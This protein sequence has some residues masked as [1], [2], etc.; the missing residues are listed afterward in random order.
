MNVI[1]LC[2]H[3]L[4]PDWL[5]R[6]GMRRLMDE[7]LRKESAGGGLARRQRF[8]AM[9]R[10]LEASPIALHTES[11]NDQHYELPAA[12]F[13]HI[14]GKRFKYSACFWPTASTSLDEAE[15]EMLALT[16]QRAE[17]ADGMS[18]LELGCGWGAVTLWMAEKYPNC[19]ITAVS[20][21]NAQKAFIEDACARRHYDNVT[22]ITAD[23]TEFTTESRFDRVV[24]VEMFEHMRNYKELMARIS[25]WLVPGGKLFVHIFCHRDL[26]YPFQVN[27]SKDWMS[28]YFFTGGLMPSASTLP[29]FQEHLKLEQQ[30]S[31]SGLHYYRT[32]NAWLRRLDENSV[33]IRRIL[34]KHY[35]EKQAGTWTQRW[36]M[37]FMA[38]AE[39]FGYGN[40]DEWFVSHYR[41]VRPDE[42]PRL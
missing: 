22:V 6:A 9:I 35:G 3:G 12:F 18:I 4:V 32:A 24:S 15:E 40:G 39:L 38:C 11:A 17:L 7:R 29:A 27:G 5:M 14:L 41:F 16:C 36:R 25:D 42:L 23:M 8:E 26:M 1:S 2:E 21:S 10:E 20:N 37:F 19:S 33:Q 30:W 34:G 31:V 13:M 28:R